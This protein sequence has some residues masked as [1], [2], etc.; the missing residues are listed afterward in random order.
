MSVNPLNDI[1]KVYL[2]QVA[3]SAVPGKPAERLGAVTAIPKSE[4]DA[5]RERLLAKAKAKREKMKEEN[6]IEEAVKGADPEMR[7]AA[8]AERKNK[9]GKRLPPSEGRGYANQQQQ[10]IAF[11]DKRSKGKFIPGMT[12][13]EEKEEKKEGKAKRWWDDDGDGKGWEEGEVS[14]KFKKKKKVEESSDYDP[15]EDPDFDHDEAEENRGVS[16]KNNPKGGKSLSKK[17]KTVRES[18]SDWR[19]DFGLYEVTETSD[20]ESNGPAKV[21]EKS[22]T[23]KV[24]INPSLSESVE[25]LGGTLVEMI[26]I[27]NFD[28]VL[29]E[30][31]ESEVF[32]LNDSLIEE[33]VEDV[34]LEC[35][36]EGYDIFEVENT[37]LESLEI[38]SALLT[39]AK[40]TLGHDTKIKSDRV[41]KVKTAVKKV[42]KAIARGAGYAAG[43]AVRG[44]RAAKREFGKGYEAGKG[45]S[46]SSSSSET[47][48]PQPYRNK[49]VTKKKEGLLGRVASK[50]KSGLKKAVAK[51]ARSLSR[52]AR[53]VARKM[54]G[55]ETKKAPASKAA[56]APKAAPK[57]AEKPS[58]PWEGSATTPAKP[59]TATKKTAAPKPKTA[60][61]KT[62]APKAKAPATS[63]PKRSRKSKLDSLLSDIRNESVQIDEKTLT[64]M[65]MSKREEI[66]RSMKDKKADFERRYPGRAEEVMYATATK[67]AK[68]IAEGA[69]EIPMT[70]QELALQQRK[71][72]L[73]AQIAKKRQQEMA[74]TGK[75]GPQV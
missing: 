30:L 39:E 69:T 20:K 60:T 59:K 28:G 52:G 31:T 12:T 70:K 29:D 33:V 65:E 50:L 27:K 10:S 71:T 73:E 67:M 25:N 42:G 53:N 16:G 37:L 19:R 3:E 56:E 72:S 5:A 18:L 2:E 35:L 4:Q 75:K 41:E 34:F 47:R 45:G 8:A 74:K 55:G 44:A 43:A 61:K 13:N 24:K 40:V 15:M 58:D 9:S 17:K 62:A 14:G 23:N 57:K 11:H 22:V 63:K 48:K 32:F 54:E 68:K 6:E 49:G 38:S 46:S 36:E 7:K 64:K 66:V 51:G 1:S 26:E 21:K